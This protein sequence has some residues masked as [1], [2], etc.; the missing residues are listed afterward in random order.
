GLVDGLAARILGRQAVLEQLRIA[1]DR[2]DDVVE[3]VRDATGE[4][5][6]RLHLLHPL[7]PDLIAGAQRLQLAGVFGKDR[8]QRADAIERPLDDRRE[9]ASVRGVTGVP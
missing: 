5:A 8:P 7:Q 3:V 4:A 1:A 2:L 6:A 9:G